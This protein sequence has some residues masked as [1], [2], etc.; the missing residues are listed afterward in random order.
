MVNPALCLSCGSMG[1]A[2]SA[3]YISH[4]KTCGLGCGVFFL[5]K[6]CNTLLVNGT[7][8][9]FYASPYVVSG[10]AADIHMVSACAC[11]TLW[12]SFEPYELFLPSGHS[13]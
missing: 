13:W 8:V 11:C 4:A 6:E 3:F 1:P 2:R 7:H 5:Q 9:M 12:Q 10:D